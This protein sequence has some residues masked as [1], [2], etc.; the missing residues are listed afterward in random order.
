MDSP[1]SKI[2]L[3]VIAMVLI[4]FYVDP[5]LANRFETIGG[6]VVGSRKI[7]LE[8]LKVISYAT[9][10]VFLLAAAATVITHKRNAQMLSYTMWKPSTVIFTLL[11]TGALIGGL[12]M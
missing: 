5:A 7:K 11:G 9:G 4:A 3:L 1:G 8:Y 10:A 6:G 12:Y 2:V